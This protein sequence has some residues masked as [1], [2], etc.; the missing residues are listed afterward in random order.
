MPNARS[1]IFQ[2]NG[3][4]DGFNTTHQVSSPMAVTTEADY[5]TYQPSKQSP[6]CDEGAEKNVPTI[7]PPASQCPDYES[8]KPKG[9]AHTS[10]M[11]LPLTQLGDEPAR[12]DCPRCHSAVMTTTHREPGAQA[13]LCGVIICCVCCPLAWIPCVLGDCMDTS[14]S[15]PQC[16]LAFATVKASGGVEVSPNAQ[17]QVASQYAPPAQMIAKPPLAHQG[18]NSY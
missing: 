3:P 14:H 16:K 11:V 15:C 6:T 1:Q 4:A 13:W 9:S 18:N 8:E 12:V 5:E 7:P 10:Q 17:T 2:S